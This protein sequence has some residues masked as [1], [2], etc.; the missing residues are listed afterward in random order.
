M[1]F[2][3]IGGGIIGLLCA[4][5]LSQAGQS[6][7]VLERG[8]VG[9]EAS[10]AGGGILSPLYP[11]RYPEAVTR[12]AL[13]SARAYP[14]LA[15]SLQASTGV[16]PEWTQSG[17]LTL[18][19]GD[20][21]QAQTWA[22]QH[23]VRLKSVFGAALEAL[24]PQLA[25]EGQGLWDEGVAQVRNPRLVQALRQDLAQA[26]VR[27]QEGVTVTGFRHQRGRL[28]AL[29]TP[30]GD[31]PTRGCLVA[32]GAWIADLLQ[33]VGLR[34]PIRPVRGQMLLLRGPAG[35]LSRIVL[36]EGRYVIPRRDGRVLVGST[37]EEVGFDRTTTIGAR[38]SLVAT[39]VTLVP[40]LADCEIERQWSG[41]RP[42]SPDGVPYIGEHP[43][44]RGLW[45]CAGHY[46]NGIVLG[47]ASARLLADLVLDRPPTLDAS[48]YRVERA[49][50]F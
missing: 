30:Q 50:A 45:V 43:E 20:A 31:I 13:W 10:W 46:R 4:R 38:E 28:T 12:L 19:A 8:R 7:S 6:A 49:E 44:I 2:H 24:E 26:G 15:M 3:V 9:R 35:L 41:L 18:D 27:F 1:S 17:M 14:Q 16:D 22:E 47:P 32:A 48:P 23:G 42:G 34:L 21:V 29:L 36:K 25:A 39:A 40:A 11:W 37:V 5:E 33:T